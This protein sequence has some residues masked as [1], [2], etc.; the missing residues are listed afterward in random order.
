MDQV[1]GY[2]VGGEGGSGAIEVEWEGSAMVTG[3][4]I[5]D[6]AGKGQTTKEAT[7]GTNQWESLETGR[8][9]WQVLAEDRMGSTNPTGWRE[10]DI[11]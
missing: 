3:E 8:A 1:E 5:G 10:K 7:G 6:M 4:G 11:E 9:Y 2:G